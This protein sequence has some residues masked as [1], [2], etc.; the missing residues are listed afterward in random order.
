MH[1][2]ITYTLATI[3]MF[4]GDISSS[5]ITIKKKSMVGGFF[6]NIYVTAWTPGSKKSNSS[7]LFLVNVPPSGGICDVDPK[8]GWL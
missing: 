3:M 6:Y 4:A 2:I 8:T 5:N 7:F 1:F